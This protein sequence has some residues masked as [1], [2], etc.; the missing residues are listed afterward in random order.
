MIGV[1]LVLGLAV[2]AAGAL[3]GAL[4]LLQRGAAG[5]GRFLGRGNALA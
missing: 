3:G 4:P 2:L 1:K 5:G